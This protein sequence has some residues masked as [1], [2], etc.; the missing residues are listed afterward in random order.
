[1]P[2]IDR[3]LQHRL[4][5]RLRGVK[6]TGFVYRL[7]PDAV[8]S[9][10]E[11]SL[12]CARLASLA[13]DG[14]MQGQPELDLSPQ[15]KHAVVI[16][17]LLHDVGHGPFSHTFDHCLG[18][19]GAARL[20]PLATE[21]HEERGARFIEAALKS[22]GILL[23]DAQ[24]GM[25]LAIVCP[26]KYEWP[27]TVPPRKQCLAGLVNS[28]SPAFLDVDR[29]DY[30]WRDAIH[31]EKL[32][33]PI[34][35]R[36][37]LA[38]PVAPNALCAAGRLSPEGHWELPRE[39]TDAWLRQRCWFMEQVACHP[40]IVEADRDFVDRMERDWHDAKL[41]SVLVALPMWYT[42]VDRKCGATTPACPP[43]EFPVHRGCTADRH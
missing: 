20:G 5:T 30:L 28:T 17:A 36:G 40:D 29:L 38:A 43:R 25:V 18:A 37:G 12:G 1:M 23:S 32:R 27:G 41:S 21:T 16:A 19:R 22:P 33:P 14:I 15:D 9:R 11:H 35:D 13:M 26:S 42:F 8:H 34:L 7:C 39:A 31:L 6:Q 3:I 24:W 2:G 4:L 10:Y